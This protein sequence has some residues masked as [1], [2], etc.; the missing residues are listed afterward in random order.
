MKFSQGNE[1]ICRY[2][3]FAFFIV[4]VNSLR[5]IKD[6]SHLCLRHILVLT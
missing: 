3:P 2:I 5:A 1:Y 6:F 4:A